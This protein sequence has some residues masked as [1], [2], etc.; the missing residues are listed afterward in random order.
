[1][2]SRIIS[3]VVV[4]TL[5]LGLGA[6]GQDGAVAEAREHLAAKRFDEVDKALAKILSRPK[7]PLDALRV[8]LDAALGSG[9][10]VTAQKRITSLL[11]SSQT[12]ELLHLG[13]RI[14]DRV[15]DENLAATRY[16]TYSRKVD[17]ATPELREALVYLARNGS[18]PDEY[19]RYVELFGA[20]GTAWFL[21]QG[22][23]TRLIRNGYTDKAIDVIGFMAGQFRDRGAPERLQRLLH[24]VA[25]RSR[26][27]LDRSKS[28]LVLDAML[29]GDARDTGYIEE[30]LRH[31]RNS[32][33]PRQRVD[34]A[35]EIQSRTKSPMGWGAVE[36]FGSMRELPS[37]EEKLEAGQKFLDLEPIYRDHP[38]PAHYDLFMRIIEANS[39]VFNIRG[40]EL[41][42]PKDIQRR[43]DT[44]KGRISAEAL[45][46]HVRTIRA[47]YFRDNTAG[48][49]FLEQYS[50]ILTGDL[51]RDLVN[52]G[53]GENLDSVVAEATR[54]A[55]FKDAVDVRSGLMDWYGRRR[56]TEGLLA[57]ARDYMSAFP[58]SFNPDHVHRSA[59]NNG[60]LSVSQKVRMLGDVARKGGHSVPMR[61]LIRKITKDRASQNARALAGDSEFKEF[62]VEF[63]RKKPGTDLAMKTHVALH[64]I[65]ISSRNPPPEVAR[66]VR[67]FLKGYGK[68]IP[69]DWSGTKTIEDV[70]AYGIFDRHRAHVWE[71]AESV[72]EWAET[73][74]PRL[75]PGDGW[76]VMARRVREHGRRETLYRMAKAML[77][78]IKDA[79]TV[80]AEFWGDIRRALNP[81]SDT[82]SLFTDHYEMMGYGNALSYLLDQHQSMNV[83]TIMDEMA[84][85]AA[86]P[87]F[88]FSSLERA[89][90]VIRGLYERTGEKSKPPV[91]LVEALWDYL[92]AEG[93][94][95]GHVDPTTESYV[96]GLLT[97]AGRQREAAR[98]L[99]RHLKSISTRRDDLHIASIAALVPLVPREGGGRLERGRRWHVVLNALKPVYERVAREDW[100][101]LQ[102]HGAVLQ[103]VQDMLG[104]LQARE[105]EEALEF[106]RLQLGILASGDAYD[107]R[108]RGALPAVTSMLGEAIDGR[109]WDEAAFL[110]RYLAGQFGKGSD[111]RKGFTSH[112]L[113]VVGKFDKA[114]AHELAFVFVSEIEKRGR[115]AADIAKKLALIK[116]RE[117]RSIP[118][119]LAVDRN[120]PT[121][122]LHLAAQALALGNEP[123]AWELTLPKLK[124]L[125]KNWMNLDPAYVAWCVEQMRKQK[126][127]KEA[128][129]FSFTVLLHEF[130]L[131]AE[132]VAS[133]SLTKGDIYRDMQNYQAARIEYDGLRKNMRYMRTEAGSKA[134]YRL[135]DLLILTK[136]YAAAEGLLERLVD[137]DD[138]MTQ[139]EAY[140][141]YAKM[142]FEQSEHRQAK[143][144]L[145]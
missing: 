32:L 10:V 6:R 136:D 145:I 129:A 58:G 15:G 40:S 108:G 56:D 135:I 137:S 75:D 59:I 49:A 44:L 9:R 96:Y 80:S 63:N 7:P 122:N 28:A 57:A 113:P 45:R 107:S 139:A 24:D 125:P 90:E 92:E 83:Q 2:T 18:Y 36:C 115:P 76:T 23:F 12:P 22:L 98:H 14:A 85:I 142:A 141:L 84:K 65:A 35:F 102:V 25:T 48:R 121:Y 66:L 110:S 93:V 68:R 21:G 67:E 70:L 61:D 140:Y 20:N 119:I 103:E 127:L 13:G 47:R 143:D 78:R 95:S 128:L 34:Y 38:G 16:L 41:V 26:L 138:L 97:R 120:D 100:P 5:C 69:G 104:S 30:V 27:R 4:A 50:D 33:T 112:I 116:A 60:V 131:D 55:S 87:E 117:A 17:R 111:W 91:A 144:H 37:D 81:R 1:M 132:I 74:A 88:R 52:I 53:R 77:P 86:R 89:T 123:R 126:R 72:S 106:L 8:S 134:K 114:G 64:G 133:V 105:K 101:G 62:V 46:N 94:R 73:W 130:D 109:A 42:G 99:A 118:D 51:C 124:V 29:K 39:Q 43:L 11:R 19:R 54:N 3:T 82:K 71:K 31:V 79:K